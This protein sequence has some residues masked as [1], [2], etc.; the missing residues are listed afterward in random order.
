MRWQL[1]IILLVVNCLTAQVGNPSSTLF[2]NNGSHGWFSNGNVIGSDY[3]FGESCIKNY[4]G[5]ISFGKANYDE[6]RTSL[7]FKTIFSIDHFYKSQY[8]FFQEMCI[9]VYGK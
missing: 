1:T 5:L 6:I 9:R 2:S 8:F 3:P 7:K 4:I